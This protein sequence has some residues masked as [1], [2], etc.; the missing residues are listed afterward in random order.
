MPKAKGYQ[1]I[2]HARCSLTAYPEWTMVK[3]EDSKSIAKFLFKNLLCRWGAIEILISDNAP[4]Y[5][6]AAEYIAEKY[7]IHHIK[8]S[9]YN[10]RAQGPIER[11]HFDVRE[12]LL[13]AAEGDSSR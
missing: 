5:L 4:Q 11:R 13:K 12:A 10:S 6:Q 2:I 7:H 8:I 9:P 3:N 1:Y